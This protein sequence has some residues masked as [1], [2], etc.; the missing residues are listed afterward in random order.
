MKPLKRK[1]KNHH[2]NAH[3]RKFQSNDPALFRM[4][5]RSKDLSL[6]CKIKSSVEMEAL[7]AK[8]VPDS[9]LVV[10]SLEII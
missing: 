5:V 1:F 2:V 3:F 9:S 4:E 6:K 8:E 10:A 7:R